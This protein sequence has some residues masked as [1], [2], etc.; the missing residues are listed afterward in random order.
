MPYRS[1]VSLVTLVV[2][3]AVALA[4]PPAVQA[5]A[6][7]AIPNT[8]A[9]TLLKQWL[10][11]FNR[12][13]SAALDAF[14]TAHYPRVSAQMWM[15]RQRATGSF[16]LVSIIS[17][18]PSRITFGLRGKATALT[19]RATIESMDGDPSH[20]KSFVLQ[21]VPPGVRLEG[22]TTYAAP[23]SSP[24]S[25]PGTEH[26]VSA[27]R[28]RKNT[29]RASRAA[30]RNLASSRKRFRG[31]ANRSTVSYIDSARTNPV[32]PRATR[33]RSRGEST[34]VNC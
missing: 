1:Y 26:S 10:D 7:V 29:R 13:D 30:W 34:A 22:C 3:A 16:D 14:S 17:G 25:R 12:A 21:Q 19:L 4:G 31:S 33:Y 18:E 6:P 15:E 28:R 23:A 24:R 32:A 9:G 8:A 2:L 27:P 11:A 5:Q 20:V